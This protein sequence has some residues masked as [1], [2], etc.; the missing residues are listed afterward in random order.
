MPLT[1]ADWESHKSEYLQK[2]ADQTA[3]IPRYFASVNDDGF[4]S[5]V[6]A[7]V[8][9]FINDKTPRDGRAAIRILDNLRR[10]DQGRMHWWKGIS[11][12]DVRDM[13]AFLAEAT[14]ESAAKEMYRE[15]DVP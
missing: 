1:H 7:D 3:E 10:V 5:N 9:K 14:P 12:E 6:A 2:V 15:G 4:H 13:E 8:L 11:P